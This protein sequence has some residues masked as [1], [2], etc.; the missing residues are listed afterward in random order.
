MENLERLSELIGID[1]MDQFYAFFRVQSIQRDLVLAFA[2]LGPA[3][4][5]CIGY[6]IL[7]IF[8]LNPSNF[9]FGKCTFLVFFC[10]IFGQSK[11]FA[12]LKS[13]MWDIHF[14]KL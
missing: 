5:C 6:A 4:I 3:L 14:Q 2:A 10:S 7:R 11:H 1:N 9:W 13:S 8:N 12:I